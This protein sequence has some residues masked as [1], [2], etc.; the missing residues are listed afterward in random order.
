MTVNTPAAMPQPCRAAASKW[1]AYVAK[2]RFLFP[3]AFCHRQSG[4]AGPRALHFRRVQRTYAAVRPTLFAYG[5]GYCGDST[6]WMRRGKEDLWQRAHGVVSRRHLMSTSCEFSDATSE[7]PSESGRSTCHIFRSQPPQDM[8]PATNTA[9]KR[10]PHGGAKHL[11]QRHQE[12][13][14]GRLF[15]QFVE[16]PHV[17]PHLRAHLLQRPRMQLGYTGFGYFEGTGD[18]LQRQFLVVIE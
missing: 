11:S 14:K 1:A 2:R 5:N 16:H 17:I 7:P 15:S 10:R 18:F 8:S 12:R 6:T 4:E 9:Q 3:F 13:G